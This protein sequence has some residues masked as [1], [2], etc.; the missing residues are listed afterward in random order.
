M[1]TKKKQKLIVKDSKSKLKCRKYTQKQRKSDPNPK[2]LK[3]IGK[4]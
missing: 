4:R 3:L 2:S 1:V